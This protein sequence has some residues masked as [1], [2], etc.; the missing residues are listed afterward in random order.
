[1]TSSVYGA[2]NEGLKIQHGWFVHNGRVIWGYG[3]HNGWWRSGQRPNITRNAPGQIGPNRTEDLDKLTDA[4]LHFAYPGFEHNY[5]LWYDRR[6]DAHDTDQRADDHAIPPFLEQP[7]ARSKIGKAYDGLPLYDLDLFNQWYF[8]RLHEFATLCDRKGA[9]M[10]HNH[11]M[12]HALLERQTH[13]VDFPWRPVNC[14]QKTAMPLDVPAAAVF[15]DVSHKVRRRLHVRYIRKSLEVLGRHT[16]VVYLCSQEYTGPLSFMQFWIDEIFRWE[17]ETGNDILVGVGGTKD[18]VDAVLADK[19]RSRRIDVIDMRLW[20][21]TSNGTLFAP[22][23]GRQVPARFSG[24]FA[25][26]E[27]GKRLQN[28]RSQFNPHLKSDMGPLSPSNAQQIYLQVLNYRK[29]FGNKA[30]LHQIPGGLRE[31]WAFLMAGGSLLIGQM[32]YPGKID[33]KTY[34]SPEKSLILQPTYRFINKHLA[35]KLPL[36]KPAPHLVH[37]MENQW[38]LEETNSTYLV[39]AIEGRHFTLDLSRGLEYEY[40]A[41]WFNPQDGEIKNTR[42]GRVQGGGIVTF[43]PPDNRDWVLWV[44]AI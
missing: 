11:Y 17:D 37:Q 7:W 3:Q 34:I 38:C 16:N 6:R 13:Y 10:F 29:R 2:A 35:T 27:G 30:I 23:G 32:P 22:P 25:A 44:Y 21:Y 5:G 8:N 20:W 18:V 24:A 14:L 28:I 31:S 33:P 42:Q 43:T 19:S 4:M 40:Q 15:Y 12:Q 26:A 41:K 1:M 9:I 36:M 39:Y